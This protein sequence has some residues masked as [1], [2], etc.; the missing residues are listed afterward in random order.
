MAGSAAIA[1]APA[2]VAAQ[3]TG[4]SEADD[5]VII[6]SARRRDERITDVPVAVTAISGAALEAVGAI[7]ITDIQAQAPNVTLENSRGTNS[8][9]TAFI[10]G[11][12]QQDPVSGFESG[13]GIYLDDVYLNRPQAA[14]LDI[15]EV[16]RVE[17]L[18]GP[19]GT[20]YGR[21]TIGGAVK[22]VTRQLPQEFALKARASYGTYDQAD[23]VVTASA[24]IGEI[25]R[26][27]V[28]GA[29]LS[30]GGFGDNLTLPGVE[31]YN[32]DVWAG[33][34]SLELGGYGEPVFIRISGDYTRDKS[35]PRNGHRLIPGLL[36]GAPVLND[37]FDTRAG[38]AKPEQDVEAYGLAM[39]VSVDLS[40][41]LTFRSI[42]AWRED[43]SLTPIDFDSLPAIDVD[44]PAVYKNEQLSQELQLLYSSDR[45]NGLVGFYYLTANSTTD[46]DVILGTTGTLLGLPGLN[47]FTSGD[48]DTETWS[49]FGDFTFDLTDQLSLS[50]GGRYT[51]DRR[52]S[53]ILRQTKILGASPIF[54]GNAVAIATVT[55]FEGSAKFTDF[56]P[57]VSLSFKPSQDHMVY[58]SYAQGFKGGSFDPR[59][60]ARIAPDTDRNGVRSYEEI[61]D[62]FLFEPETV[63][64]YEVGY[65]ATL[66]DG[67]MRLALTGFYSDYK[68]VQ[69]PGSVGVD[70][71]NDGVFE[72]FAGVTTNAA[73]ARFK[74]IELETYARFAR[75]FAGAGSSL[76]FTGMLGYIDGEFREYIVS[77]VDLSNVRKIQNTPKWTTAGTLG[78]EVPVGAGD[79]ALST[80]LSYRSKTNQFETPSPYLDQKGYA[81]LDAS[82]VWTAPDDRFSLGVHGRNL[83][84]KR[85]ITSGYQFVLAGADG[86]PV[87]NAAGNPAPTLGRE[88]VVTA[89]Y[90]NPRQ[91]YATATVKF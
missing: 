53:R 23:L 38:L 8:T 4:A 74:G 49:A 22:Y 10:R 40:D 59:G 9:L 26:F 3:E 20:L 63:D 19:Q 75:D 16:E 55:D 5:S 50:A 48:V 78:A 39:N 27:G 51:S 72:S 61:Y 7:D 18:R 71:N 17:V 28:S 43:T 13:V 31:N 24:P 1:L 56:N 52:T 15:Y 81:L 68:D 67:D 33:R 32:K 89:F 65:K 79:L 36:S 70:A 86:T 60:D 42:S 87:L 91:V 21:N 46:F 41:A 6:V 62:F 54:G 29:R 69:I 30:R 88:G 34:A 57:R 77:G 45:L 11:V 14:V 44:V 2:S 80:T 84:D 85:Y 35:D 83:T 25:V 47:A 64:T 66:M 58:A 90:G 12:G 76:T 37:V 73:K 82:I